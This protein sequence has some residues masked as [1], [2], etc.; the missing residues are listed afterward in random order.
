MLPDQK[1]PAASRFQFSLRTLF[2]A[3][4]GVALLAFCFSR[5]V[6]PLEWLFA[7][8]FLDETSY[9]PDY[10]ESGWRGVQLGMTQAQVLEVLG[11]PVQ[12]NFG[13]GAERW[14][15]TSCRSWNWYHMREV[16]FLKGKVACKY[17]KFCFHR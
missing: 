8:A 6:N 11:E 4:A 9:S 12:R 3:T 2:I 13:P 17:G 1:H 16:G 5:P 7:L 10:T 14:E 15:Y